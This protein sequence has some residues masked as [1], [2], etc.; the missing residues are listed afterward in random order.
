MMMIVMVIVM[1][2]LRCARP[3]M[4]LIYGIRRGRRVLGHAFAAV[5][6]RG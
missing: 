1:R 4:N 6:D 3:R 2:P 5:V